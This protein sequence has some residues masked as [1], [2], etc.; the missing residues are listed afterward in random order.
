[1]ILIEKIFVD[2]QS[3]SFFNGIDFDILNN[4]PKDGSKGFIFCFIDNWVKEVKRW[5]RNSTINSILDGK[6]IPK[7]NSENLENN[8]VAIY[9]LDGTEPGVLFEVIKEKVIN[10]NFPEHSWI[11]ISGID[12]GAWKIGNSKVSN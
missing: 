10:R 8:Y 5:E 12:K 9:Q 11:P 7:F 4:H 3:V 2:G 1:M 6:K